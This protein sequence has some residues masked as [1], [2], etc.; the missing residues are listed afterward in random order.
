[1]FYVKMELDLET[2]MGIFNI[3]CAIF[4]MAYA[5]HLMN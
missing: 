4:L 2:H 3:A 5:T 1:M